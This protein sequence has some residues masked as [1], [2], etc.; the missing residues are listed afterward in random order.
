M[1]VF[2]KKLYYVEQ[3]SGTFNQYNEVIDMKQVLSDEEYLHR[4]YVVEELKKAKQQTS[5]PNTRWKDH[6][7]VWEMLSR[8]YTL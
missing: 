6:D 4:Q 2:L 7:S 3:D 8:E 1:V 5:D